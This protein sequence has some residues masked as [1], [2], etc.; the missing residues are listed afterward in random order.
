M[1]EYSKYIQA[2]PLKGVSLNK[3][4]SIVPVNIFTDDSSGNRSKKW[5]KFDCWTLILPGLS[6]HENSQLQNIHFLTCSNRASVLEMAAPIVT[7]LI[8]LEKGVTLFDAHYGQEIYVISPVLCVQC[9]NP[10]ASELLN[11]Q[12]GNAN[13]YCRMCTVS[14]I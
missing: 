11:H 1:Q 6:K 14:Y 5:N 2:H 4:I 9:D 8:D 13:L 7:D 10:R 3:P 12:G